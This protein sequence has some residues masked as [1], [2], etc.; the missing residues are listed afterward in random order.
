SNCSD[1]ANSAKR[2]SLASQHGALQC[3][4][5]EFHSNSVSPLLDPSSSL[6]NLLRPCCI[7]QRNNELLSSARSVT[8]HGELPRSASQFLSL[9]PDRSA[10]PAARPLPRSLLYSPA[11]NLRS[12]ENASA[13]SAPARF[14]RF[15]WRWP[16]VFPSVEHNHIHV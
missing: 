8:R 3:K 5:D 10:A 6:P 14:H 11:P 7:R 2:V 4:L 12:G 13:A 15:R 9:R 16:D 1:I